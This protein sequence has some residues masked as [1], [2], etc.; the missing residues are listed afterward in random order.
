MRRFGA[1]RL[2]ERGGGKPKGRMTKIG[3]DN[4]DGGIMVLRVVCSNLDYK[5]WEVHGSPH[6]AWVRKK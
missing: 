1:Y 5:A 2:E 3:S 4:L 6:P